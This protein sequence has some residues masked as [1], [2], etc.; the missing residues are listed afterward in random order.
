M[1]RAQTQRASPHRRIRRPNLY[2][3]PAGEF[4]EEI[5]APQAETFPRPIGKTQAKVK[6]HLAEF[7][8]SR[9]ETGP[10]PAGGGLSGPAKGRLALLKEGPDAFLVVVAGHAGLHRAGNPFLIADLRITAEL[11]QHQLHAAER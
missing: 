3:I 11:A 5:R 7:D 6:P 2:R 10:R 4:A 8:S 1:L 9:D